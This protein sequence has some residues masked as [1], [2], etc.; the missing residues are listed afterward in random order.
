MK[1]I[2]QYASATELLQFIVANI[3]L[4]YAMRSIWR[5]GEDAVALADSP[6][7][8]LRRLVAIGNLRAQFTRMSVQGILVIIGLVSIILPPPAG[9]NVVIEILQSVIIRGG[10][11]AVTLLLTLDSIMERRH[12][13]TFLSHVEKEVSRNRRSDDIRE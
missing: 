9:D 2:F 3:G 11:I 8:D 1:E 7:S 4:I 6:P 10:M 12:R 13:L 5:A